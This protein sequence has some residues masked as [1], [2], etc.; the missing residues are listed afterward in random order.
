MRLVSFE[1][2]RRQT[3]GAVVHGEVIEIGNRFSERYPDLQAG[4]VIEVGIE[5]RDEVRRP[6]A[7]S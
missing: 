4:D 5:R 6:K 7:A 1:Q 3:Y 2:S